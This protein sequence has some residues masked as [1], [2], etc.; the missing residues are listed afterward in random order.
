MVA[1][2]FAVQV[3]IVWFAANGPFVDE[4]LYAVARMR[5]LEGKGLSDGYIGWFNGCPFVWP[6]M[7]ALGHRLGGLPGAR[8][9]AVI[10]SVIALVAF[11]KT[12]EALVGESAATA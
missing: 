10:A 9:M 1:A 7:A 12:A 5:V 2:F 8:S 4:G 6:V 11:A 3:A